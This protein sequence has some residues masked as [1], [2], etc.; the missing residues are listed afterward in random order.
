MRWRRSLTGR[1]L[2]QIAGAVVLVVAAVEVGSRMQARAS[3]AAQYLRALD[4]ETA[5]RAALGGLRLRASEDLVRGIHERDPAAL[6]SLDDLVHATPGEAD[7]VRRALVDRSGA[8]L[9]DPSGLI[10]GALASG[11]RQAIAA[12]PTFAGALDE[13]DGW[14]AVRALGTPDWYLV[15]QAPSAALTPTLDAVTRDMTQTSA[16]AALA[17]LCVIAWIVQRRIARP[18]ATLVGAV[19]RIGT[20]EHVGSLG[21]LPGRQDEIGS[22]AGAFD[23]MARRVTAQSDELERRIALRTAELESSEERYRRLHESAPEA[24]YVLDPATGCVVSVNATFSALFG[25]PREAIVGLSAAALSAPVQPDGRPS[26]DVAGERIRA[27]L[28]NDRPVVFE[29]VIRTA[30]GRDVPTEVR[31]VP[32]PMAD[33]RVLVRGSVTDISQRK[34]AEE[35]LLRTLAQERAV[36]EMRQ[37][38]VSTV[39]HEFR[40]P[41]AVIHSSVEILER[42]YDRL[43]AE[44][45]ADHLRSVAAHTRRLAHM[46]EEVLLMSRVEAG[47]VSFV[48]K[49]LAP[50]ALL[51]AVTEDVTSATEARCPIVLD[52]ARLPAEGWG[53]EVILRHVV[54]N[55]V[56]NAVK[57]SEAGSP[58]TVC[59]VAA[60]P[61][62]VLTVQDRG[63][64]IPVADQSRLFTA[65][66]RGSNVGDRPGTGLGLA[67]VKRVVAVHRGSI[68]VDSA[69]GRGTTVTVRV[70][71][72]GGRAPA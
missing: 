1:T 52:V 9:V 33:G 14:V 25:M 61:M 47:R 5:L 45:R 8:P 27:T 18:L 59:G 30:D 7:G 49:P 31:A 16:L 51:Q 64:G 53:D 2:V 72:F 44:A 46:T 11:I 19:D 37:R 60:G 12:G 63:I 38:F 17:I 10:G 36:S 50:R 35:D 56:S 26:E 55:L 62:A 66:Q 3:F 28:E 71:L 32:L 70:P 69:V 68:E 39:S 65:F 40:T 15:A 23:A 22:L 42:Y 6:T 4:H 20:G 54:T 48:P 43:P 41:L 13:V 34:C 21:A 67:I 57:Y 58:V 29:W 24:V